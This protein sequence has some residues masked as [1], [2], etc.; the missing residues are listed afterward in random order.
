[1]KALTLCLLILC[2]ACAPAFMQGMVAGMDYYGDEPVLLPTYQQP[3]IVWEDPV[4]RRPLPVQTWGT[5]YTPQ[6]PV[7]WSTTEY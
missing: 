4:V 6:G 2:S 3:P 1:M 5:I 7:L